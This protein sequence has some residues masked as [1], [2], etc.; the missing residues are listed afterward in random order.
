M[1]VVHTQWEPHQGFAMIILLQGCDNNISC[2]GCEPV[3][4][5]MVIRSNNSKIYI[6]LNWHVAWLTKNGDF[7]QFKA[8]KKIKRI[9]W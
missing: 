9:E 8:Y 1:V 6:C 5:V 7:T 3:I 2:V 4:V